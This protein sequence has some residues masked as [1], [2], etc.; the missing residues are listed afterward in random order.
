MDG[1][2]HGLFH[3]GHYLSHSNTKQYDKISIMLISKYM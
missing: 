1:L 2:S 3:F